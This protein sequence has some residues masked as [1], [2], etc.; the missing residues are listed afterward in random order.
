MKKLTTE[1]PKCK[2]KT[3]VI[4]VHDS[5][6]SSIGLLLEQNVYKITDL[7]IDLR[8][9][10]CRNKKCEHS[11]DKDSSDLFQIENALASGDIDKAEKNLQILP[12]HLTKT[13]E[14]YLYSGYLHYLKK[15]FDSAVE[16]FDKSIVALRKLLNR[17]KNINY[18][19]HSFWIDFLR[20][21]S[22]IGKEDY[23]NAKE[24]LEK[25]VAVLRHE[26]TQVE[27]KEQ[28]SHF[29]YYAFFD[30]SYALLKIIID[31]RTKNIGTAK[32]S[33]KQIRGYF[34]RNNSSTN[35]SN[36]ESLIK[37]MTNVDQANSLNFWRITIFYGKCKLIQI[38]FLYVLR[39]VLREM[40]KDG[41]EQEFKWFENAIAKYY[42]AEDNPL[43]NDFWYWPIKFKLNELK[44]EQYCRQD[45]IEKAF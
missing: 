25:A 10:K 35:F 1:C 20:V 17:K 29:E 16:R 39:S 24:I 30:F 3:F 4:D 32:E 18:T 41:R 43:G 19:Y 45:R 33:F 21:L 38:Q 37:F 11:I 7:G 31:L 22:R 15:N 40:D 8:K 9:G 44:F 14:C 13:Y 26:K 2:K 28:S 36:V 6:L 12:S 5:E 27:N 23:K 42:P 34:R